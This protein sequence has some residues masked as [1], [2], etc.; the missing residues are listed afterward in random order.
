MKRILLSSAFFAV[1]FLIVSSSSAQGLRLALHAGG[2]MGKIDSKS[3]K[4]EYKLGYH[5]AVAP[6][7]MFSKKVGNSAGGNVQPNQYYHYFNI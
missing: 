4:D 3:F 1:T 7:I 5:L 6:E 2:N